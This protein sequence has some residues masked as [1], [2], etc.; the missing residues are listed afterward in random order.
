[1]RALKEATLYTM[2]TISGARGTV[3]LTAV[4][5]ILALAAIVLA[6]AAENA[7]DAATRTGTF[8][9]A[10]EAHM[11]VCL[12]KKGDNRRMGKIKSAHWKCVHAC[13]HV[14]VPQLA[15][16]ELSWQSLSPSQM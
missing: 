6:V 3:R 16:S 15:S 8:K 1:M 12:Q 7:G 11:D 10:R 13:W 9:L 2:K 5:L 4:F 14:F